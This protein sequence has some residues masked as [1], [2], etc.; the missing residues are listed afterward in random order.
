[1]K[2]HKNQ[3]PTRWRLIDFDL[4]PFSGFLTK[5]T[6]IPTILLISGEN[7]NSGEGK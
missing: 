2:T 5:I 4:W 6:L 3:L 1:M 7:Y